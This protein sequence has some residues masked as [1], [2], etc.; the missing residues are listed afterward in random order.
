[1]TILNLF[2]HFNQWL[3]VM[4]FP[5][6]PT[7]EEF[8][9]RLQ[10]STVP[11]LPFTSQWSV[12]SYQLSS[13]LLVQSPFF[14]GL[15][16]LYFS[17]CNHLIYCSHRWFRNEICKFYVCWH[18]HKTLFKWCWNYKK[19]AEHTANWCSWCTLQMK[20]VCRV[21]MT[22]HTVFRTCIN[23]NCV[24]FPYQHIIIANDWIGR[25]PA[26]QKNNIYPPSQNNMSVAADQQQAFR[27]F[28]AW[29]TPFNPTCY[30]SPPPLQPQ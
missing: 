14:S 23:S 22:L 26:T 5:S 16:P 7:R 11:L 17:C 28:V 15:F 19:L 9:W 24:L 3:T 20:T 4:T 18:P 25:L 12:Y 30:T 8:S 1:M 10:S 2:S 21:D 6:S 29:H 13:S 27:L